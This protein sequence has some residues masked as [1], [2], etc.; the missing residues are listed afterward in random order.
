[1]S[2]GSQGSESLSSQEKKEAEI[3]AGLIEKD[4]AIGYYKNRNFQALTNFSI[5]CKGFVSSGSAVEGYLIEVIPASCQCLDGSSSQSSTHYIT[6]REMSS[7]LSILSKIPGKGFWTHPSRD[8]YLPAF[9][10]EVCDSYLR[11]PD[12]RELIPV[13][14]QTVNPDRNE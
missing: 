7:Q 8:Q 5:A 4:G 6:L 14:M 3:D 13:K 1:M 10:K 12:A 2:Q 9:F 11:D